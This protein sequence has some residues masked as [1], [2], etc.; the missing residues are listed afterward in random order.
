M[1][2]LRD[3]NDNIIQTGTYGKKS[4]FVN[5]DN[6]GILDY[7]NNNL[8]ALK[9]ILAGAYIWSNSM[10][11]LPTT[12]EAGKIYV[13]KDTGKMYRWNSTSWTEVTAS[14]INGLS[15]YELAVQ[16]G[17]TGTQTEWLDGQ[18]NWDIKGPSPKD[19]YKCEIISC[20]GPASM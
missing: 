5:S 18:L 1:P 14:Q 2:E 12:G 7:I 8:E 10:A 9:N 3:E 11:E 19:F 6:T 4:T 16:H 20:P 13:T 15:A 17:Y